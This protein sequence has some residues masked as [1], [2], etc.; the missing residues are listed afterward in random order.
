[1]NAAHHSGRAR[2]GKAVTYADYPV[3]SHPGPSGISVVSVARAHTAATTKSGP[4]WVSVQPKSPYAVLP[5][6]ASAREVAHNG[7]MRVWIS[8]N[9]RGG[10][11]LL[12][13]HPDLASSPTL[14]HSITAACGTADELARGT[15]LLERPL[16]SSLG[17]W[18][19]LG[20]VPSD[21]SH[22]S[23]LL[24][25]GRIHTTQVVHNFYSIASMR[26]IDAIDFTGDGIKQEIKL[27]TGG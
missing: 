26:P 22:V 20:A 25:N 23:A 27:T 19:G 16:D 13:F 11:C 8:K 6:I 21:V 1:M 24:A 5:E 18:V 15:L 9:S 14:D 12:M 2:T 10:V 17:T 3:L 7:K 4:I